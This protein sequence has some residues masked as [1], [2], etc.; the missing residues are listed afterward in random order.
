MDHLVPTHLHSA[1]LPPFP[2]QP[3]AYE[4]HHKFD[5]TQLSFAKA[6]GEAFPLELQ[7]LCSLQAW[8]NRASPEVL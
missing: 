7:L 1:V 6:E 4:G 5:P 2:F 3:I 8:G